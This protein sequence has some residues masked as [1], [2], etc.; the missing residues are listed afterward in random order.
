[1][2]ILENIILQKRR[3]V[4]AAK[5]G[6]DIAFFE[7][8]P[9][10]ARE[11]ISLRRSVAKNAGFAV[12]AEFKRRSPSAGLIN[13][14]SFVSDVI[15]DY[16]ENDA[17]GISILTDEIFFGGSLS[18]LETARFVAKPLLRKD[19]IIDPWQIYE[20]KA[21]GADAI[22]LIASCLTKNEIKN[23][24][25][26]ARSIGLETLLELHLEEELSYISETIDLVGIN[27][28]NLGNFAVNL[29]HSAKMAE[30]IGKDYLKI[31][32]SGITN[33]SDLR[34]LEQCGFDGFLIGS[35]FMKEKEPGTAFKNFIQKLKVY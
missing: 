5:K 28:R 15:N 13:E 19:F 16:A 17:A 9:L 29:E 24:A 26:T 7:N 30:R 31:A 27:N 3:E 25:E 23:L 14:H 8:Q 21:F 35:L 12:I 11:T 10:F 34:Y 6:K 4:E 18:D 2:N 1:M 22:L 32:E 20:A 33:L